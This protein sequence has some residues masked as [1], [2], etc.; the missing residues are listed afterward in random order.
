MALQQSGFAPVSLGLRSHTFS[1][2]LHVSLHAI[3]PTYGS[4]LLP[5]R[6]MSLTSSCSWS[7]WACVLVAAPSSPDGSRACKCHTAPADVG[8][9]SSYRCHSCRKT[10]EVMCEER[11]LIVIS[12]H[13]FGRQKCWNTAVIS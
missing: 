4:D 9:G 12:S 5:T 11:L 10:C 6:L 7:F 8:P 13:D 3:F 1:I 2:N